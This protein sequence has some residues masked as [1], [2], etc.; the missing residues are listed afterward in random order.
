MSQSNFC[1]KV[2]ILSKAVCVEKRL[3]GFVWGCICKGTIYHD[4]EVYILILPGFGI[5]SHVISTFSRKPIFGVIGMIHA[6]RA[7]VR[8]MLKFLDI[9]RILRQFK[10]KQEWLILIYLSTI[11]KENSIPLKEK[12]GEWSN[13][14]IFPIVFYMFCWTGYVWIWDLR[15]PCNQYYLTI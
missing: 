7:T 12:T 10:D 11:L 13:L 4:P 14:G 2:E 8:L 3:Y 1:R 15:G 5:I 6:M 9:S